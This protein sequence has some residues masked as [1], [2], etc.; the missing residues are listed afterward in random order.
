LVRNLAQAADWNRF[1]RVVRRHRV[2]GLVSAALRRTG[3]EAGEPAAS[4]LREEATRI[5]G[6]NLVH[7]IES[8]RLHRAFASAGL[9]MLFVKGLPLSALAFGGIAI[10]KAWDIDLLVRPGDIAAACQILA[11]AGYRRTI[12]DC[13]DEE[14]GAWAAICKESLWTHPGKGVA[15]ELHSRLLDNPLLLPAVDAATPPLLVEVAPGISLPTLPRDELFAY[16]CVHGAAH[17]WSRLK[18]LADVA[19]LIGR[20]SAQEIERLYCRALALGAGR[21]PAQALLLCAELLGTR[22]PA[23]LA[24]ELSRDAQVRRLVRIARRVIEGRPD[25]AELDEGLLATVPILLGHFLMAPG[26]RYKVAEAKL[27]AGN[28]ADRSALPPALRPFA[29]I[30]ALPVWLIRRLKLKRGTLFSPAPPAVAP[31]AP[32]PAARASEAP[33]P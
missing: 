12:P 32:A 5:A 6:T 20:D 14:F 7:A 21:A 22:L 26:W 18:W 3:A 13:S 25:Q 29:P 23:P 30:F 19:A 1:L 8:L 2:E 33:S 11:D 4:L 10:K 27:K 16:M 31:A 9:P 24:S 17:G 15:V 28:A